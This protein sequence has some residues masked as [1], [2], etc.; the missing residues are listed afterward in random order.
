V[1]RRDIQ[2]QLTRLNI[3]F[4]T[5]K[6]VYVEKQTIVLA[7][8]STRL[9]NTRERIASFEPAVSAIQQPVDQIGKRT[10]A[11]AHIRAGAQLIVRQSIVARI[12][13]GRKTG[14]L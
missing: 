14:A 12:T 10:I 3:T 11:V 6:I 7:V 5:R 1:D 4:H 8:N 9:W 13:A 2:T